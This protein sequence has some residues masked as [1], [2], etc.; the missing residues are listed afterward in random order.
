ME[1][2]TKPPACFTSG[3][4]PDHPEK[5]RSQDKTMYGLAVSDSDL[6]QKHSI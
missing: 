1:C 4:V 5:G 3:A 6:D 2:L